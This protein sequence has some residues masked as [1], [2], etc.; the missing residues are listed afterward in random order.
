MKRTHLPVFILL[1]FVLWGLL[2]L[3]YYGINGF[4]PSVY[5]IL[6]T[7]LFIVAHIG[8]MAL[9]FGGVCVLLYK[10]D[11]KHFHYTAI[12]AGTLCSLLLGADIFI[13][14]QYRAHLN[15]SMVRFFFS[16]AGQEFFPFLSAMG[17]I[18]FGGIVLLGLMQWG[19]ERLSTKITFSKKTFFILLGIW[20]FC[21]A[22]YNGLYAWGEWKRL[23]AVTDQRP[24]L[25]YASLWPADKLLRKMGFKPDQEPVVLPKKHYLHYP[26]QPLTCTVPMK[27]ILFII[28][29]S[30]RADSVTPDVMPTL[31]KRKSDYAMSY[32]SNHISAGNSTAAG[33]FSLF[34]SLP[35]SYWDDITA[36]QQPPVLITQAQKMGFTTAVFSGSDLKTPS[37]HRNAFAAIPDLPQG[38]TGQSP[39]ENDTQAVENFEKFL[40]TPQ[41][42]LFLAT[43]FLEAPFFNSYPPKEAHFAPAP[44]INYFLL[45]PNTPPIPYKNRYKNALH[46]TDTLIERIFNDLQQRDLLGNTL[47]IITGDHGKEINDT[48][49]NNWAANSNFSTYQTQVPLFVWFPGGPRRGERSALTSHFDIVPTLMTM[50]FNCTTATSAYSI[51]RDLFDATP[52]SYILMEDE[53]AIAVRN[54]NRLS[55]LDAYGHVKFYNEN[56]RPMQEGVNPESVNEALATQTRFYY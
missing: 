36:R 11:E 46:F 3:F 44:A 41:R 29:K 50:L 28:V 48:Q 4:F 37:L 38:E 39:W 16:P 5:G 8:L 7:T 13:F 25:P 43:I 51:G 31:S 9:L 21:F 6:F 12:T 2:S 17:G 32:F 52:H 23:P 10:L 19:L 49:H 18:F 33:V 20:A 54:D 53:Q 34:Y 27:N 1:N 56:L 14:S 26:L 24:L 30:W 35:Y 47:V 45:T 55:I 42:S 15:P 22:A 40:D